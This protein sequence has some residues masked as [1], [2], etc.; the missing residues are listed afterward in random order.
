MTIRVIS[1]IVGGLTYQTSLPEN[2]NQEHAKGKAE[3]V[4][5]ETCNNI[6]RI[7]VAIK[8]GGGKKA[9]DVKRP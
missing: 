7:F 9:L 3:T 5:Q 4:K 2:K 8:K 6:S 1:H